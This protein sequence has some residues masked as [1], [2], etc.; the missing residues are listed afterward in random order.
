MKKELEICVK[1]LGT[2]K[3]VVKELKKYAFVPKE[4]FTMKDTYYVKENE[5]ITLENSDK[6]LSSYILIREVVGRDVTFV[7]KEK[8]FNEKGEIVKQASCKCPI[9]DKNKGQEFLKNIGYKE[10]IQL[11]DHNTL[12]SNGK[13]EI[14]IQDVE[15]LGVYLE[16]EQ[17]NLHSDNNNG[18]NIEEMKNSLNSYNLNIEKDNYFVKKSYDMLKNVINND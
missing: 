12:V 15:N 4:D 14:Y 1:Y 17:K 9:I 5:D 18:E 3:D 2:R 6:L 11:N 13:N 8:Q 16:M 7:L 10:L